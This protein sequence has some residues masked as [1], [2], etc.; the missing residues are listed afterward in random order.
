M[1]DEVENEAGEPGDALVGDKA[2]EGSDECL[3]GLARHLAQGFQQLFQRRNS[4]LPEDITGWLQQ[5]QGEIEA[6][7]GRMQSMKNAA[8]SVQDVEQIGAIMTTAGLVSR[9][10]H[11]M[12]LREG[13]DPGAWVLQAERPV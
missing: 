3:H 11:P 9:E 2:K 13:S 10:P 5:M 8:L 7:I 6:F 1:E 4:Y 12:V